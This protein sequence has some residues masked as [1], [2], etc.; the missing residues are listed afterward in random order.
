MSIKQLI[1]TCKSHF[2]NFFYERNNLQI[3]S[4]IIKFTFIYLDPILQETIFNFYLQ[5]ISQRY[6]R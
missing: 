3:I 5:I 4:K 2:C 1:I 6:R